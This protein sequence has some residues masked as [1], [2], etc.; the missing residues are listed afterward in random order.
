MSFATHF[1]AKKR[2]PDRSGYALPACKSIPVRAGLR[3][4]HVQ[5]PPLHVQDA[6]ARLASGSGTR[7]VPFASVATRSR[8]TTANNSPRFQ[9]VTSLARSVYLPLP[10]WHVAA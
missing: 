6:F 3:L 2:H 9:E 7:N 5:S 4:L 10:S 1:H 8:T